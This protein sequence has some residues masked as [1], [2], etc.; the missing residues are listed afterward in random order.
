MIKYR[1][2]HNW[3]FSDGQKKLVNQYYNANKF[4]VDC[5]NSDCYIIRE[6]RQQIENTLLSITDRRD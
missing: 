3:Q 5:L 2:T 4:L 6:V 1:T